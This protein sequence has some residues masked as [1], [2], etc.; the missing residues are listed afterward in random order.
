MSCN[1]TAGIQLGCRDNV[2]GLKTIWITDFCN[3]SSVTQSTGDTITQISGTGTFYCFEL[4]RT[5]SQLT[6]TVN[7]SLENGTVFYQGEVVTYFS[8]LEQAKRNILKTLAQSQRL[9]IVAE[10]NNGKYFYLGQTYGS[11]ISAGT[12]VTGKAL[13]DA[14]GYNLTF[15]YL[16]PNPMNELSGALSSV[17]AGI[18]VGSCGC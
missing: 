1:L 7:A 2:G 11:F 3:I 16:E 12:S 8:K 15:Q 14:A 10:D 17:V 5:S 13:G 18:T 6:E 9:A 4:I